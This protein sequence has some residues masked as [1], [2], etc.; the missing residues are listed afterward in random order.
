VNIKPG[1]C[2]ICGSAVVR[3]E[4]EEPGWRNGHLFEQRLKPNQTTF[5]E[6][7]LVK[8]RCM[9]HQESTD[10]RYYDRDGNIRDDRWPGELMA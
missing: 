6:L 1:V 7:V 5:T 8:V 9:R 4:S 10:P 3:P 2:G